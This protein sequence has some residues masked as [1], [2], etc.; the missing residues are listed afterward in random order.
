L[1]SRVATT[2][3]SGLV[4]RDRVPDLARFLDSHVVLCYRNGHE[5]YNVHPLI[6]DHVTKQAAEVARR[7][8]ESG[9]GGS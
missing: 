4:D 5:W 7:K 1:S 9:Q 3:E 6:R 8:A 2:H